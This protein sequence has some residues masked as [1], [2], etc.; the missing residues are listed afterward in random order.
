VTGY[1]FVGHFT[2]YVRN[3]IVVGYL[4]SLCLMEEALIMGAGDSVVWRFVALDEL[5]CMRLR[6]NAHR[7]VVS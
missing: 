1:G 4:E 5:L 7:I 6:Q 3:N 2:G